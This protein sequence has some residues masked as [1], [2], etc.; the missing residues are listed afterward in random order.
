[1]DSHS[2]SSQQGTGRS[3]GAR[4]LRRARIVITVQRT[5]SYKQWL[6]E[7]PLQAISTED[8]DEEHVLDD[9]EPDP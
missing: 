3:P 7:N 8:V 4:E 9:A 2:I 5:E 1:M 6:E